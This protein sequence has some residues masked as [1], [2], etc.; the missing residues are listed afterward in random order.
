MTA[1]PAAAAGTSR[2]WAALPAAA[3]LAAGAL[4]A[5]LLSRRSLTTDEAAAVAAAAGP[6]QDVV[7]RALEHDP[8]QAG[9]LALL[10]PVV[11]WSDAAW[12]ARAP[13]VAAAAVAAL[14]GT[15][16]ALHLFGR[17]A[18]VAAAAGLVL[19]AGVVEASQQARP[20]ALALAAV[21]VSTGLLVLAIERDAG[22]WWALYA[23]AALALPLA[24]PV[25]AS[26]LVAHGAAVAA[27]WRD[28]RP[29]LALPALGL[30]VVETGLLLGA[31]A[32]ARSDTAD[33][34][35][36]LAARDVGTALFAAGGES[37]ILLAAAA[38]GLGLLAAG[39]TPRWRPWRAVLVW[40]L[41]L[42]PLAALL[43]AGS[44]LP[45]HPERALVASAPG[46]ALAAAAAVAWVPARQAAWAI[47][48]ALAVAATVG[49]VRW[50]AGTP[51]EDWS[52]AAAFVGERIEPG[53]SVVVLPPRARPAF[54]R[55]APEIPLAGRA[56]GAGAW[57]LV[58]AGGDDDPVELARAAVDT[59]RYAL[60]VQRRLGDRL[61][62]QRWVRP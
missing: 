9:Y 18:G 47:V 13:S 61:V 58:L 45:V 12:A 40:G 23:L 55:E 29:R 38:A 15:L 49:L 59:P 35:G 10:Q 28:V 22:Q 43:L 1:V 48:G 50:Y 6:F 25:A 54:A 41:V 36:G 24:H 46:L 21:A 17:L 3:A 57:V 4:G 33:G 16:L 7:E 53:Q 51:A 56:R 34:A 11:S 60:L 5:L 37:P 31:A 39:R 32:V 27:A 8:A 14:A 62:V 26:A 44:F 20:Y 19:N 30:V 42:G 52:A 2:L